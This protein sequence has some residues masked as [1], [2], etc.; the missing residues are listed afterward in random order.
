MALSQPYIMNSRSINL[1]HTSYAEKIKS[2]AIG[3]IF[4][5][6]FNIFF[7]RLVKR[8][9]FVERSRTKSNE[10]RSWK[11]FKTYFFYGCVR[12]TFNSMNSLNILYFLKYIPKYIQSPLPRNSQIFL[13][14]SYIKK[15]LE[16]IYTVLQSPWGHHWQKTISLIPFILLV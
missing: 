15:L 2:F 14:L 4:Q 5:L 10:C 8:K 13:Y 12:V 16:D 6:P 1:L 7:S 11:L 9:G 3:K